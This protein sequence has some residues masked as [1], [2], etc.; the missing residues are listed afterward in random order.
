V[1]GFIDR[2]VLALLPNDAVSG[3]LGADLVTGGSWSMRI[4]VDDRLAVAVGEDGGVP[5]IS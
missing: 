5:K 3:E 1:A 2:H 4:A